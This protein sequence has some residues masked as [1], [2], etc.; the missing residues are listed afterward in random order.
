[1]KTSLITSIY[2]RPGTIRPIEELIP[3]VA[4]T[5]IDAIEVFAERN[6]GPKVRH[7]GLDIPDE[8]IRRTKA[9]CD[10]YGL[11]VSA[12]SAHFPLI[13]EDP[14][15]RAEYIAEYKKCIDQ[16]VVLGASFVHG[17][18]GD[19]DARNKM[20]RDEATV[21]RILR[22]GC[23]EVLDYAREKKIAFGMEAVV[24]H[25]VHGLESC[26]R[27]FELVNRD[28]LYVNYDPSHF[29]LS[30]RATDP[31]TFIQRHGRRIRHVHVH[32]A[33]GAGSFNWQE[34]T[35]TLEPTWS[36]FK[37]PGMG[38]IDLKAIIEELKRIGYDAYLSI[39]HV[40]SGYEI[41]DYVAWHYHRMM[42]Q[43]LQGENGSCR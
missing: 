12:I 20:V 21:W 34:Y 26:E 18:S 3:A 14:A 39:E 32:D 40:G 16:A 31:I 15:L 11:G 6:L 37:A 42:K 38:E 27:M 24:N 2:G 35:K 29:Y 41:I 13:S 7:A 17:F 5:G 19:P 30:G 33:F 1:M 4:E 9:L 36:N 23:I 25:L 22:Q 28:D 8:Q 43:Y 10:E